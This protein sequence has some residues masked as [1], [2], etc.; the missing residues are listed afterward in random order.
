MADPFDNLQNLELIAEE[1]KAVFKLAQVI[2]SARGVYH[3]HLKEAGLDP[4]RVNSPY[5]SSEYGLFWGY[6]GIG[7]TE[8]RTVHIR[9]MIVQATMDAPA[10]FWLAFNFEIHDKK[11]RSFGHTPIYRDEITAEITKP[12]GE[13]YKD[14]IAEAIVDAVIMFLAAGEYRPQL[15]AN[16][17]KYWTVLQ[18]E[19]K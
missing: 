3:E 17:K 9:S 16:L 18:K 6:Q 1:V 15:I 19:K 11:L 10:R 2:T 13:A 4:Q 5:S 14:D 8:S 12:V 7:E